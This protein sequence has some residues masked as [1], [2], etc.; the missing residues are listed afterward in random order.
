MLYAAVSPARLT[1]WRDRECKAPIGG[2]RRGVGAGKSP[3]IVAS[4]VEPHSVN[5][6]AVDGST[7]GG[8]AAH[9]CFRSATT[10]L[11]LHAEDKAVAADGAGGKRAGR[12]QVAIG[13]AVL[14]G[15]R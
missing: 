10:V 6:A 3:A 7:G 12:G 4:L 11:A 14:A 8:E 15:G 2:I 1:G 9:V 13:G 5:Y